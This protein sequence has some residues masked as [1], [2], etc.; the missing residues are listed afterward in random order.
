MYHL[1]V[2]VNCNMCL[3]GYFTGIFFPL[4]FFFQESL[5]DS[6]RLWVATSK[7]STFSSAAPNELQGLAAL[8]GYAICE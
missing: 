5:A 2:V 1:L 3:Q 8:S 4:D 7:W 6:G